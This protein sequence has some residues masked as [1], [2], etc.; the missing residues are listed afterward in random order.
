M[1]KN[2]VFFF[3]PG[4]YGPQ[5]RLDFWAENLDVIGIPGTEEYID[6]L[7][8]AAVDYV[9]ESDVDYGCYFITRARAEELLKELQSLLEEK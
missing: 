3:S 1:S 6:N 4:G 9:N 7:S 5:C 2:N 8:D